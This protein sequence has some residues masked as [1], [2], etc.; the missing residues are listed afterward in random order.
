MDKEFSDAELKKMLQ[1][2]KLATNN[3]S[4]VIRANTVL[5]AKNNLSRLLGSETIHFVEGM[6]QLKLFHFI[7]EQAILIS[8]ISNHF[9]VKDMSKI[10]EEVKDKDALLDYFMAKTC[11]KLGL[12]IVSLRYNVKLLTPNEEIFGVEKSEDFRRWLCWWEEWEKHM[13]VDRLIVNYMA[14]NIEM[15]FDTE[16]HPPGKWQDIS[17]EKAKKL[18]TM[19]G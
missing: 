2:F 12:I 9:E 1:Q 14:A 17:I 13:S 11:I 4:E 16:I 5:E 8:K 15:G 10:A 19:F 3:N 6:S 18:V 7:K